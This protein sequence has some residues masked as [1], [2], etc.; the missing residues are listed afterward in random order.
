M[1]PGEQIGK[2]IER[3]RIAAGHTKP[4][5]FARH[6]N[7]SAQQLSDWEHGRNRTVR[8]DTLLMFAKGIP[9]RIE[10]LVAGED[11]DYDRL[12]RGKISSKNA[13][14]EVKDTPP[15]YLQDRTTGGANGAE[16]PARTLAAFSHDLRGFANT[17]KD[18]L[19]H[20]ADEADQVFGRQAP[21]DRTPDSGE[22]ASHR[23]DR[24]QQPGHPKRKAG[25]R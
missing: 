21:R 11:A 5:D 10:E 13:T 18:A 25:P 4:A 22:D 14:D 24:G 19:D 6:L 3:L 23:K 2:N 17:V 15:T 8:L 9:C 12:W 7:I 20:F 1:R 16:T